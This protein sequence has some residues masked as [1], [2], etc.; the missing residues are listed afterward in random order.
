MNDQMQALLDKFQIQ[1][2]LAAYARGVD[3]IDVDR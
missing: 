2:V 1:Q 3:R